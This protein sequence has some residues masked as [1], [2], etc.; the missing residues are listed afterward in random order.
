MLAHGIP[1]EDAPE[2]L[3]ILIVAED[4]SCPPWEILPDYASRR[5]WLLARNY[6]A[7]QRARAQEYKNGS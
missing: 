5:W 2:W 1:M 6:L 4:W 3:N 7:N